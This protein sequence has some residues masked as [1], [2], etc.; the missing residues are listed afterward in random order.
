M[1]ALQTLAMDGAAER[2]IVAIGECGL[3]YDRFHTL[4]FSHTCQLA[5]V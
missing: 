5:F 3:D 4:V 2:K 1:E